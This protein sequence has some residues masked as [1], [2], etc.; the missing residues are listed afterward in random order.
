MSEDPFRSFSKYTPAKFTSRY[1]LSRRNVLT[2]LYFLS[3]GHVLSLRYF[4]SRGHV[5]TTRHFLSYGHVLT[6]R[7]FLLRGHVLI[8]RHFLSRGHVLTL[9]YFL[10]TSLRISF[11]QLVSGKISSVLNKPAKPEEQQ[12]NRTATKPSTGFCSTPFDLE[13]PV[14]ITILS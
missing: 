4:L 8:I 14:V 7:Y 13:A 10:S 3:R 1:F 5:L 2:L 9:R 12:D 6:L 11:L